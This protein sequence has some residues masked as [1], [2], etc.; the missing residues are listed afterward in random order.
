MRT[1]LFAL[2]EP[3]I[4]ALRQ[5]AQAAGA[6][7]AV[8]IRESRRLELRAKALN[9]SFYL[10]A[11]ALP[12]RAV[13]HTQFGTITSIIANPRQKQFALKD[14]LRKGEPL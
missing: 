6:N 8:I 2:I 10:P 7:V 12:N 9:I 1:K 4:L 5:F 11:W 3:L 14:V 13:N